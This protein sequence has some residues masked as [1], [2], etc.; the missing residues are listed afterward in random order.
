MIAFL[1]GVKS[2][3]IKEH[4]LGILDAILLE[5]HYKDNILL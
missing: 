3:F 2:E 5:Q 4:Q 1:V